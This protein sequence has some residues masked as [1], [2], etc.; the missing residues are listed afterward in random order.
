MHLG[1]NAGMAF[2]TK[3]FK[4]PVAAGRR[5]SNC[6]CGWSVTQRDG[7][8]VVQLDT[9]GSADRK[10]GQKVSQSLQLDK[11]GAMQLVRIL[12]EAFPDVR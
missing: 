9:Y 7:D 10:Y 11:D 2:I 6:E 4:V 8:P 3:F 1:K 12:R 5:H